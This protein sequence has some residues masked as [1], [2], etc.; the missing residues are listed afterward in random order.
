MAAAA[1]TA[2]AI[3]EWRQSR[4]VLPVRLFADA[5]FATVNAASVL[6]GFGANGA[7][8]LLSL[9]SGRRVWGPCFTR[10]WDAV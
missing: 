6:L 5:R 4:P 1:G 3:V 10:R 9:Y 7:F 8:T 2:F